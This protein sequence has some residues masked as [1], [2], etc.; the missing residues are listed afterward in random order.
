L[1]QG[2]AWKFVDMHSNKVVSSNKDL[3]NR[4]MP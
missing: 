1:R 4:R 3:R 2:K